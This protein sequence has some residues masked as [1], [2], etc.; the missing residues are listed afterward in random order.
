[1]FTR[2]SFIRKTVATGAVAAAGVSLDELLHGLGKHGSPVSEAHV[3]ALHAVRFIN[4]AQVTYSRETGRYASTSELVSSKIIDRMGGSRS[5][6]LSSD[7]GSLAIQ[8]FSLSLIPDAAGQAYSLLLTEAGTGFTYQTTQEGMIYRGQTVGGEFKGVAITEGS[9]YTDAPVQ[10]HGV[11]RS[12]AVSFASWIVPGLRADAATCCG[13]CNGYCFNEGSYSCGINCSR[14]CNLG[15]S[16][17]V[18]CCNASVCSCP[19]GCS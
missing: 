4:S 18:W 17:C 7:E 1:M 10:E 6:D 13:L 2:R 19:W 8:G 11:I 14:C 16:S 12:M 9:A 15:F 5:I 3:R